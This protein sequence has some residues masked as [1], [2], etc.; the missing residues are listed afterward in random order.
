MDD[1]SYL[2]KKYFID[3]KVYNCPFCKRNNVAFRIL[4]NYIFDWNNNKK[5]NVIF[6]KCESCEKESL[7]LS[8][9][10]NICLHDYSGHLFFNTDIDIDSKIFYSKPTSFFVID[11]RIPGIIRELISEA[12]GCLKMDFLTGSSACMRKAIYELL[13]HEKIT[14][15][16]YEE[17]I[18]FLKLK[19]PNSDPELF[20][21][22]S[23]I[24]EMTSD[25]IHEQSWD[26]WDSNNLHILIE[27]LKT[28]L[29][30]IY[31]LPKEREERA[32]QI[33]DLRQKSTAKK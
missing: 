23:H 1:Q 16:Y 3:D 15:N 4:R 18:K 22:L 19:F 32:R 29:Y 8:Y 10:E 9:D 20:D 24:Q 26:E 5:C 12:E 13:I 33:K 21:I 11:N 30:E 27:T 28:I 14:G 17:K 7:H 2:D 25:K 31:V 6:V